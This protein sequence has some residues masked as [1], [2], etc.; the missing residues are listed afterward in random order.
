LSQGVVAGLVA[1]M[2]IITAAAGAELEGIYL[3]LFQ[4]LKV[5]RTQLLWALEAL[6]ALEL[7]LAVQLA[8]QESMDQTLLHLA[9]L[10]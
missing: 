9:K 4:L 2:L 10:F 7:A 5:L 8:L 6:E 3:L 1:K